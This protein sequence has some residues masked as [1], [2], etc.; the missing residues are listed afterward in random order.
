MMFYYPFSSIWLQMTSNYW[1][2]NVTRVTK[3]SMWCFHFFL[4]GIKHLPNVNHALSICS[5]FFFSWY[6]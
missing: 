4:T 5:F 1:G 3:L 6:S 2:S